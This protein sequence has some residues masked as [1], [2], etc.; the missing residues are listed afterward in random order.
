M[1]RVAA[2]NERNS[3]ARPDR[4]DYIISAVRNADLLLDRPDGGVIGA[5][6]EIAKPHYL[7]CGIDSVG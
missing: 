5:V 2:A 3:A 4:H 6:A 7:S 1:M